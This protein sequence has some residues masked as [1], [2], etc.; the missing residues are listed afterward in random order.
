MTLTRKGFVAR[1]PAEVREEL[2]RRLY[3]GQTGKQI[4]KWLS[5][6]KCEGNPEAISDGHISEWRKGGYQDWLKSEAQ[7]EQIRER[8]ELSMRMAQAAGGS[9]SQSMITRIAGEIDEQLDNLGDDDLK[10]MV[11]V[12]QVIQ[13]G[14][15]LRLKALRVEQMGEQ[16]TISRERFQ[17]DTCALFLKWFED[18]EVREIAGD[19]EASADEKTDKLGKRIFG[20]DWQ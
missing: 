18:K 7:M 16:V 4:M 3:N 15:M 13:N 17:R 19:S 5:T 2:N 6:L 1:L 9:L 20:D 11:P 14:E 8:A 12:L 10:K